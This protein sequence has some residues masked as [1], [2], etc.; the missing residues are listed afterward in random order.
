M[1]RPGTAIDPLFYEDGGAG[2]FRVVIDYFL[3][4]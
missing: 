1:R 2:D 4:Y 3:S